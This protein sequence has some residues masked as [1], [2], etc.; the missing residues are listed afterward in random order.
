MPTNPE[1][2]VELASSKAAIRGADDYG[3]SARVGFHHFTAKK[4][5]EQFETWVSI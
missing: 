3:A 4:H 1:S 5:S 2:L